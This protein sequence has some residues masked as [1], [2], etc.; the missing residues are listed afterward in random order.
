MMNKTALTI[1]ILGSI[2]SVSAIADGHGS[3]GNWVATAGTTVHNEANEVNEVHTPKAPTAYVPAGTSNYA[4]ST[5]ALISDSGTGTTVKSV[6]T[7]A[8][9]LAVTFSGTGATTET[10]SITGLTGTAG[11]K[12]GDL[13]FTATGL[14][15]DF[16]GTVTSVNYAVA[17]VI[18][19][20]ATTRAI[21]PGTGT[22][23]GEL[24]KAVVV[25]PAIAATTTTAAVPAV[26]SAPLSVNGSWNFTALPTLKASGTFAGVKQ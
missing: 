6:A 14:N 15:G 13:A 24:S 25:T 21:A 18:P 4:G 16:K 23:S 22:I 10:G 2:F 5:L 19:A 7:G 20:T 17:A 11:A 26:V 8:V 1:A 3:W 12:L 9:A